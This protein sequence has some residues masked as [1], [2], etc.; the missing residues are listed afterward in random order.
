MP[1]QEILDRIAELIREQTEF[2]GAVTAD[3]AF[4]L[5][6]EMDSLSTVELISA[7]EQAFDVLIPYEELDEFDSVGELADYVAKLRTG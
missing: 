3:T 6:L 5:D 1:E 7:T 4:R 2:K